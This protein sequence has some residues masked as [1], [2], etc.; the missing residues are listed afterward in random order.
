MPG[1]I[2]RVSAAAPR[3]SGSVAG[4]RVA[5]GATAASRAA[6]SWAA[7]RDVGEEEADSEMRKG[8]EIGP[9][10]VW[11]LFRAASASLNSS[12]Q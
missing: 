9:F 2:V 8:P 11:E 6:Q 7:Y 5:G 12:L 4:A 10:L 3:T 1:R